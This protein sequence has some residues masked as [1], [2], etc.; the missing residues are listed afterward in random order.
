MS[1]ADLPPWLVRVFAFVF[2]AFFGSFFNVAIY[3]WPRELS[4]VSPSRSHCP[5]C[6]AQIPGHL[7]VPILGYLWLRGRTA[8]CGE[9]LSPRYLIVELAG[10]G[11]CLALAERLVV[12][13]APSVEL[14]PAVF[15]A[16]I[17]FA[18][19]GGLLIATFVDLE[20]REIPDEVSI[21]GTALGLATVSVR[22][23]GPS[24]AEAALGAGG[25]FLIVQLLLVWSWEQ[26]TGRRGM[27]EGDAKL[28]MF[29]GAF[30]GWQGALFALVAG[31]FQG[32]AAVV[33]ATATGARLGAASDGA[34]APSSA[35][36]V[37]EL[38]NLE[39][40]RA[41][42]PRIQP[43]PPGAPLRTADGVTATLEQQGRLLKVVDRHDR[44]LWIWRTD[45]EEDLAARAVPFGPFL[46]LGALEFLFFGPQLV[47]AYLA[48][49]L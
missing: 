38:D 28:L 48:L 4:V 5:H 44:L 37:T 39:G 22:L 36:D 3:R 18:F 24:P 14:G 40:T 46:A 42:S 16:A 35:G 31:A 27:G 33:V 10:A 19:V 12:Q 34:E 41:D 7:N 2:G 20:W 26:L 13:A 30:L 43:P 25:A 11:L 49:F 21:A 15:S 17:E 23:G 29:I 8:C 45:A 1:V 47:D 9:R 6:G 32:I